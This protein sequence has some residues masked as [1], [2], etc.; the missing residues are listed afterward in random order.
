MNIKTIP[1]DVFFK[2]VISYIATICDL[3]N[4]KQVDKYFQEN[5]RCHNRCFCYNCGD[6][7]KGSNKCNVINCMV[8]DEHVDVK[9][10]TVS[11]DPL[12]SLNCAISICDG[13]IY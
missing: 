6:E 2:H 3:Q 4:L 13:L 5:I 1:E 11:D 8:K 9:Y 7:I 10:Y 12:C